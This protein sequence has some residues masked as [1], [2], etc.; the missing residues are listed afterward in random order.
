MARGA[1]CDRGPQQVGDR[2]ERQARPRRR[3]PATSTTRP[4]ARANSSTSRLRPTPASPVTT[5]SP[6]PPCPAAAQQGSQRVVA[7]DERQ[8]PAGGSASG[9]WAPVPPAAGAGAG[10]AG[11]RGGGRVPSRIASYTSVVACTG[12]TPS[13][14]PSTRT[15]RS[16]CSSAS[17]RR[18]VHASSR[19]NERCAASCSGSSSSQRAASAT[20][21]V[22]LAVPQPREHE[23]LEH[24]AE[25][26]PQR[27]RRPGH[28]LVEL[29][30][31]AQRETGQQFAAHES[32]RAG[33]V[34]PVVG[35]GEGPERDD[36]AGR[37]RGDEGHRVRSAT[38]AA[39]VAAT[40]TDSVRRKVA[41]ARLGVRGRP[42]QRGEFRT[43]DLRPVVRPR[44]GEHGEQRHRL[45]GVD[46]HRGTVEGHDGGAQHVD[47]Q[48][49]TCVRHPQVRHAPELYARR[50]Y[51]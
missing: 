39:P 19:I 27:V 26:A 4:V 29:R 23:P 51:R 15:Q 17:C 20:P 21:G 30:G 33:E 36:V 40:S 35:A 49:P 9:A 7:P 48:A 28:P 38:T 43:R 22:Q 6:G 11:R 42:Q 46:G 2:R 1:E 41:R 16:Y 50:R 5:T 14:S 12:A 8:R 32:Y 45:A 31:V 25:L 44:V 13:S 37:A 18:P 47:A 10:G 3:G 34:L 24:P